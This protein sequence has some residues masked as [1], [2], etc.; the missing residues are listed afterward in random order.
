MRHTLFVAMESYR[1]IN[2]SEVKS[3]PL[4]PKKLV[5]A[6][7]VVI[8]IIVSSTPPVIPIITKPKPAP[9]A[10]PKVYFNPVEYNKEY[11]KKNASL[12]NAKQARKYAANKEEILLAK[13]LRKLNLGQVTRPIDA[14]IEK[15]KLHQ[16]RWSGKWKSRLQEED[17]GK[18]ED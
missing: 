5:A 4:E 3:A 10:P 16:D 13:N 11:R 1:K 15:Y 14:S 8:P 18:H 7:P 9:I 12:L 17:E 2:A 6:P